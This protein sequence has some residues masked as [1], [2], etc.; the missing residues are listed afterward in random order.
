M[1][2]IPTI[3]RTW[4]DLLKTPFSTFANILMIGIALSLPVIG[5]SFVKSIESLSFSLENKPHINVYISPDATESDIKAISGELE[6]TEGIDNKRI[7]SKQQALKEF[8]RSSG[9]SN[10]LE[11]LNSNPL[12]TTIVIT[13]TDDFLNR[14][15]IQHLKDQLK[16]IDGVDE[17]QVN[18]EWLERLNAITSFAETLLLALAILIASAILLTLSNM[19]RLLIINRKDEIVI[20]KLVGANDSYVRLPFL[21]LGFFY[22]L[23]GGLAAYGIYYGVLVSLQQPINEF[24]LSYDKS[25]ELYKISIQECCALLF[26]SSALGWLSA[27]LSV[28]KHLQQIKPR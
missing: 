18:Q 27:R 5:Y 28:G 13:P 19:V 16:K 22:G 3:A 12:P 2:H 17:I 9:I 4:R 11:S 7:I 14:D 10:V 21:Y 24:S 23:L 1:R 8:E 26:A 20:S 6:F 25:F 15:G